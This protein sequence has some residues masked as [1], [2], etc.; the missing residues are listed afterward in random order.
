M[1]DLAVVF[2][3]AGAAAAAAV[4]LVLRFPIVPTSGWQTETVEKRKNIMQWQAELL[5]LCFCACSDIP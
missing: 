5:G 4:R 1:N 2:P 3:A